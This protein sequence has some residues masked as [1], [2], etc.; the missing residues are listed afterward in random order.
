MYGVFQEKATLFIQPDIFT[1]VVH[2][3]SYRNSVNL[4]RKQLIALN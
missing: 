1:S 2:P 3:C 4:Y